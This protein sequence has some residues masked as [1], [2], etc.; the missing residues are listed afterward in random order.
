MNW[1]LLAQAD[2]EAVAVG[3]FLLAWF[4]CMGVSILLSILSLALWIWMLVDCITNEPSGDNEKVIWI[5]V[6]VFLQALGAIIYYFVRRP[7]RLAKYGR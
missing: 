7:Q 4:V 2:G 6:L 5:L 1:G 3:A